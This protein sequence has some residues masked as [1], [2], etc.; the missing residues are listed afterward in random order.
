MWSKASVVSPFSQLVDLESDGPGTQLF[1]APSTNPSVT[2]QFTDFQLSIKFAPI[3]V[4]MLHHYA[5]QVI[6]VTNQIAVFLSNIVNGCM[7]IQSVLGLAAIYL[8]CTIHSW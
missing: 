1:T 7:N 4:D 8:I 5:D 3:I 6:Q 2:N